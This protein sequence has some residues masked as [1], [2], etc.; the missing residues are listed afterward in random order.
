MTAK[1]LFLGLAAGFASAIIFVSAAT[2][3]LLSRLLLV[4]LTPLPLYLAG[5]GLGLLPALLAA[6]SA[7][8]LIFV[9]LPSIPTFALGYAATQAFP[10][11]V[12]TRLVLLSRDRDGVTA[13]YPPGRIL[14]AAALMAGAFAFAAMLSQGADM[15]TLTKSVRPLIDDFKAWLP[16]LPNGEPLGEEQLKDI[17]AAIVSG[18]PGGVALSVM[19]TTLA[20]LWLAGRVT[21]AAGQLKRPWPDFTRLELPMGSAIILV[22]ATAVSF[23]SDQA[24]LLADGLATALRF[25]FALL[26]LAVIHYVAKESAWRGF[27]LTGVYAA[28]FVLA[29]YMLLI[30]TII[31][32]AETIFHYRYAARRPPPE[33]GAR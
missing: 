32:L 26:G 4:M 9:A 11:V 31:G 27:M 2:G 19:I 33:G 20:S 18:I 3:P 8:A 7:T 23:T 24:W 30:L 1:F 13:W 28:L 5:L 16:T 12:L 22:L 15:E 6:V 17:T 21:L 14:I 25:A 10:A 29:K